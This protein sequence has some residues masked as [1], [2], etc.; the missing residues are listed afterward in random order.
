MC[1]G[2][3]SPLFASSSVLVAEFRALSRLSRVPRGSH[4][5]VPATLSASCPMRTAL[6]FGMRESPYGVDLAG[7]AQPKGLR[8]QPL[9]YEVL[10]QNWWTGNF[11][12]TLR[13]QSLVPGDIP[14]HD[15]D[16]RLLI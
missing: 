5:Q 9:A 15:A 13:D 8:L 14:E 12:H 1:L 4:Y 3:T 11:N 10:A 2:S 7:T 6:R 16:L